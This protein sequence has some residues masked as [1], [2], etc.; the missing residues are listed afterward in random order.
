MNGVI[1]SQVC[2]TTL[3]QRV[4]TKCDLCVEPEQWLYI[5]IISVIVGDPVT[6]GHET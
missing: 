5:H 4:V 1:I 3:E 2:H 6:W